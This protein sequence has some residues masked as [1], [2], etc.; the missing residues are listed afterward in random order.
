M[1]TLSPRDVSDLDEQ[2]F[3]RWR[4]L[5]DERRFRIEQLDALAAEAP[6]GPR[7]ESVNLALRL[8][9]GATLREIDAALE[10]MDQGGYGLCVTCS[11]P[12]P[13]SRLDTL[14]MASLCMSCHYNEQ[15][16]RIAE[17]RT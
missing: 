3:E 17:G 5:H 6:R 14:P 15:N 12:L 7:H 1:S 11:Q 16:C 10:R 13:D 9:A 8:A 2:H 4:R